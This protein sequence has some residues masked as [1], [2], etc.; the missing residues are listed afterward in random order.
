MR[1]GFFLLKK[2]FKENFRQKQTISKMKP[3]LN[4]LSIWSGAITLL[5]VLYGAIAFT[6]TDIMVDRLYGNKRIGFTLMLYAYALYRGFRIYQTLK[7]N[8]HAEE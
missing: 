5:L 7:K 6:F 1:C 2:F 4:S 3:L 8:K